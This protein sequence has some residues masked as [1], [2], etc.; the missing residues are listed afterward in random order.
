ML[1]ILVGVGVGV[2]GWLVAIV[3]VADCVL[4]PLTK[5]LLRIPVLKR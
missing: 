5:R 3:G 2:P 1:T 4:L